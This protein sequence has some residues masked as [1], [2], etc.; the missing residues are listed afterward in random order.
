MGKPIDLTGQ[1]FGKLVALH[2][3]EKRFKRSVVWVCKCECGNEKE[4][5]ARDLKSGNTSSCGCLRNQGYPPGF[6]SLYSLAKTTAKRRGLEFCLSKDQYLM[7]IKANCSYCGAIPSNVYRQ[8]EK[9]RNG[10]KKEYA[11]IVYNG[12]DRV[13][14]SLGYTPENSVTSCK[15]CN[16][17]K[18]NMTIEEFKEWVK[19]IYENLFYG[20]T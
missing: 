15:R 14:S 2:P 16:I 20:A 17:A 9:D 11:S 6:N 8:K 12:I 4:V 10:I 7:L 1:K 18:N 19:R 5:P 3:T 13:D